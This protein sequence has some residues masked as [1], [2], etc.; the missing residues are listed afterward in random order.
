VYSD[1]GCVVV[2]YND[3][4]AKKIPT[5]NAVNLFLDRLA[6]AAQIGTKSLFALQRAAGNF[7]I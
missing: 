1:Y 4:S 6:N 7:E 2:N 3:A 5:D